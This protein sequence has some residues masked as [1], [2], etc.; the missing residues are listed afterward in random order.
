[1]DRSA[2]PVIGHR[3]NRAHAPENTLESFAQ[4]VAASADAIELDV[5]ITADGIPVVMHDPDVRRTTNGTGEVER[6]TF[7][8]IR[9]LDAGARFTKDGGATFPY[10]GKGH[11]VPSFDEV[12]EAFPS[13][14]IIIEIKTTSAARAVRHSIESHRAEDR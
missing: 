8:E 7:D 3:G 4:A 12:L 5:R 11:R 6:L 2:R 10:L 13:T 1:M 9:A 14:P